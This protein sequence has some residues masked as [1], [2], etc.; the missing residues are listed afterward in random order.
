MNRKV[1]DEERTDLYNN[2]KNLNIK[3]HL[4]GVEDS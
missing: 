4:I 1:G 2:K 3:K